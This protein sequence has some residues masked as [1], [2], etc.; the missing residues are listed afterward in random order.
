MAK[1]KKKIISVEADTLSPLELD[2]TLA[3]A[4]TKINELIDEYGPT[5]RFNWNRYFHHAYD[6][7]PSP[8]FEIYV[9]REETDEE[10][11]TR[12]R[13]EAVRKSI[14]DEHDRKEFER[15]QKKFGE[16]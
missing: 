11:N 12:T 4:R 14:Q 1:P 16:K 3:D 15:L 13:E 7:E 8:R 2:G 5:A 10:Y 9:S 6:S